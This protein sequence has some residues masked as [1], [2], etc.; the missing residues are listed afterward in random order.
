MNN[1]ERCSVG[2]SLNK[3]YNALTFCQL[4]GKTHVESL[5]DSDK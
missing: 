1:N 5:N 4:I 2:I 3:D